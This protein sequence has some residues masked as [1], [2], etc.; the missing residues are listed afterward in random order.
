M[1]SSY[2]FHHDQA[3]TVA[4]IN[5]DWCHQTLQTLLNICSENHKSLLDTISELLEFNTLVKTGMISP[6][7][8]PPPD[9]EDI[10]K[11]IWRECQ[12]K[13][14]VETLQ[15]LINQRKMMLQ[16]LSDSV[17]VLSQKTQAISIENLCQI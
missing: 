1:I 12:D 10:A 13:S 8:N 3:D 5:Q 6:E 15:F 9:L 11:H 14:F 7:G 17:N 16:E 4:G 2:A